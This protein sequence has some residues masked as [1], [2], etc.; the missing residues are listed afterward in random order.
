MD[1]NELTAMIPWL[2]RLSMNLAIPILYRSYNPS[3]ARRNRMQQELHQNVFPIRSIYESLAV[4]YVDS[5]WKSDALS[6]TDDKLCL[7]DFIFN[8][9]RVQYWKYFTFR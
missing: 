3:L 4:K 9:C 7:G 5:R 1:S 8:T 6:A 2:R